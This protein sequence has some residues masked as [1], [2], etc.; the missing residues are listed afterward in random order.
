MSARG[1]VELAELSSPPEATPVSG[2][3]TVLYEAEGLPAYDLPDQ[4]QAA[5][6]GSL[7][8][9]EP[10]LVANFVASVDGV[11]ALPEVPGDSADQ[12]RQLRRPVRARLLRACADVVL[13]GAGTLHAHPTTLWTGPHA[14]PASATYFSEL[15][16]RRQQPPDP[17]LAVVTASGDLNVAHPALPAD[18]LVLTSERGAHK[19]AGRLPLARLS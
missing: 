1:S 3:L 8:F 16:R 4:L 15:L 7:G 19:L 11:V 13:I 12:R 6:G 9:S 5:Y 18:T 2:G 10:R 17:L 14:H